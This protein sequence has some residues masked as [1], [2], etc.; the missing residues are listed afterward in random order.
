MT[1]LTSECAHSPRAAACPGR[2]QPPKLRDCVQP[3]DRERVREIV[4]A[5]RF[6]RP[7]EIK[8]AVELVDECLTRGAASGYKF[9]LADVAAR[10]VG[11][12][13][14]GSIPCTTSSF[15]LYWIAV[16]PQHQRRGLGRELIT[17]VES[18]IVAAGGERIYIDTSG[19][20]QYAS[21]RAFY[22]RCGYH[23]AA[24]LSDFYAP[25]DDRVI[26]AKVLANNSA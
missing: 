18:R 19:K 16:D 15:D 4:E 20:P 10:L 25:G 3:G 9:V 1:S 22:E 26:F 8:I 13:C 14:Y 6:F 17:A 7:D 21:T 5:T 24:R 12:A 2:E 11:Y 23:S